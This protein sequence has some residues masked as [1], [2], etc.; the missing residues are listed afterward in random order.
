MVI[1]I[2]HAIE[3]LSLETDR[4]LLHGEA[5][6]I[7]MVVENEIAVQTGLLSEGDAILIKKTL[8]NAGLPIKI[9]D[10]QT[11]DIMA[12]MKSDKKNVGGKIN[13]TLLKQL[14]QAV[15]NQTVSEEIINEVLSAK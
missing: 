11:K 10:F 7:G 3:A 9:P 1:A 14:G 4:P 12:K 2:G 5:I 13:F 8:A 6:S 15:I